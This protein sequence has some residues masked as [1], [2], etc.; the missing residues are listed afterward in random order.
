MISEIGK[1]LRSLRLRNNEM[2][3]DMAEFLA[4]S[5]A[6]L[7]SVEMGK[8]AVP[9]NWVPA[10][11]G[12]YYL[13]DG[14]VAELRAAVDRSQRSVTLNLADKSGVQREFAVS[15]ARQFDE[16]SDEQLQ[17]LRISLS[18]LKPAGG[19]NA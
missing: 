14:E 13:T 7:S 5:P 10:I 11:E 16:L 3:K 9:A 15:F 17:Q 8:K 19:N 12:R 6:F 4:V 18:K 1:F 2:L